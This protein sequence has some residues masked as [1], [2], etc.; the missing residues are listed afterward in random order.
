ME[1]LGYFSGVMTLGGLL[2]GFAVIAA[3]FIYGYVG[4]WI[5]KGH[6]ERVPVKR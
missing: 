6:R 4:N 2:I 5:L 1:S 3:V